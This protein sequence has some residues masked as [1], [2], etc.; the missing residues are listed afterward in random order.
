MEDE[1]PEEVLMY[2]TGPVLFT[3]ACRQCLK[4]QDQGKVLILPCS[5]FYP[6]PY[7]LNLAHKRM[8]LQ[9]IASLY[10]SPES[11]A[12]HLWEESWKKTRAP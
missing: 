8:G 5:Y 9:E 1:A 6:L 4:S 2:R 7:F 10:I 11:M 12:V 3:K